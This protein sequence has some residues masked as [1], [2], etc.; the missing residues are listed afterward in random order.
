MARWE[1]GT[2]E[3][4]QRAALSLFAE[5]GY[6]GTTVAGIAEEAGLTE[7]TFYRYF[8]DKRDVLFVPQRDFEQAF[9]RALSEDAHEGGGRD[10]D[11]VAMI[12]VALERA[13][14]LFPPSRKPWSR[15]RQAVIDAH[16][17]LQERELLKLSSLATAMARGLRERGLDAATAA[18]VAET[19]VS[20]FRTSFAVWL[21]DHDESRPLVAAQRDVLG[22]LR[23]LL[24]AADIPVE[25]RPVGR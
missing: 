1:S 5:R 11:A 8:A 2:R 4:L 25:D 12:Q 20:V 19:G 18:L 15:A 3:R 7:R 23:V 17:A 6:D 13:A 24:G 21:A 22:R 10:A 16:P 9:L 14:E